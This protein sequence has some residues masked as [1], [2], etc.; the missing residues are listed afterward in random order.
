MLVVPPR[1]NVF[2]IPPAAMG[3]AG[4]VFRMAIVEVCIHLLVG[5]IITLWVRKETSVGIFLE[6]A[7]GH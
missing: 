3:F 1:E 4:V 2:F 7:T 6:K 5:T